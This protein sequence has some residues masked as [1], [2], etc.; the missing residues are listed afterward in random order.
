MLEIYDVQTEYRANP[1]G[2]DEK[3][4]AFS[5]KLRSDTNDTKQTGYRIVVRPKEDAGRKCVWDSHWIDTDQNLYQVYDGEALDPKTEYLVDVCVEDNYGRTANATGSFETGLMDP[6]QLS[7]DFIAAVSSENEEACAVFTKCFSAEKK[8]ARARAYVSALGVYCIHLNGKRVGEDR[9]APGWT[10]YEER[11]QYQTYDVTGYLKEE[12]CIEITVGN[13]WYKGILGFYNQG[14]HYGKQ[15]AVIAE[16]E[17]VYEDGSKNIIKTD[18]S[19]HFTTGPIRYSEIYHGEV[20]DH[21]LPKQ[22]EA[23]CV[24][25][26][27]PKKNLI[28]Q[29]SEP[30]RIT[31][32]VAAKEVL[33]SPAGEIIIDFGQNLTG[34]VKAKLNCKAGTK[35]VLRHAE[36]LDEN[37]NLFT[38]NLRTARATDTFITGGTGL[39]VFL[40]EFTFHGFRYVA[41]EGLGEVNPEDFTAC[42]IHTDFARGGHFSCDNTAVDRLAENIDWTMRS[43]YLDIP[44]DCPQRDERLGYTGDAEIFLPTALFHGNLALFYRKWLRDLRVEQTEEYGVPLTVPDI[45]RTR[46]CVS[47]WHDAAAIVPWLIWQTY[48]DRRVLEEQYESMKESVEYTRRQAGKDGL[49]TI[50]NSSQFGD[51]VAL[52][53]PKGP[54]RPTEKNTVLHPSMDE[55]GGGTDSH[56]IGNVYYLYSIDILAKSAD[57]LGRSEDA[58]TYRQLYEEVKSLFQAEYITPA[59]RLASPTQTAAALVLYFDLAPEKDRKKI[60]DQL[61]LQLVKTGKHLHT[62][63]VGTE[64]LPHVLSMSGLHEFAGDILQKDDCP[65]WIYEVKLGATTVWEL[66]DGVNEDHSFNLFTMNSLNQYGFATI[67]DWMVKR[68]AG[69]T[70]LSP[71]YRKSRI[72]PQLVRGIPGVEASYETPYGSIACKLTCRNGRMIADIEIPANTE[73]EVELPGRAMETLGSGSYHFEYD[74]QLSFEAVRYS[75]DSTLKQLIADPEARAYFEEKAP[76]LAKNPMILNFAG[77]AS[78]LE[79][80]KTMPGTMV[81]EYAYPIFDEMIDLLNRKERKNEA[82]N[83]E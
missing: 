72:A 33:T 24:L 65:S 16:I 15:T 35:V 13:G 58:L 39:E 76:E 5:W 64:Y 31:Q 66:W 26:D 56:L 62:G 9:F 37:G 10:S 45:L 69:I 8:I 25:V 2:I 51:W 21:S 77:R 4:P 14:C 50:S 23:S 19:W 54:F 75:E 36:A 20:I 67:G 68:L 42:V 81:P 38:A 44:M 57:V 6:G 49:L 61:V 27:Y 82:G 22:E 60:L 70:P 34:V 40:P 18:E 78:V 32:Y 41:V 12:N 11:L 53:A 74:T 52:D 80:K 1:L 17:L 46:A 48:G 29:E 83:R 47:I 3:R 79:I 30:V 7:A 73:A 63:F 28:A 55:K 71:G 43:N 59:G